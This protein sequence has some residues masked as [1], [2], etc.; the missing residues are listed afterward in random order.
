ME[1]LLMAIWAGWIVSLLSEK[2][3]VQ[4]VGC[5]V[6]ITAFISILFIRFSGN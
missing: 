1:P 3:F 2:P 6:S 4:L 5:M